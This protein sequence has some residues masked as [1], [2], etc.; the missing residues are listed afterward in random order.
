MAE[1][2]ITHSIINGKLML[3][4]KEGTILGAQKVI[5]G[6]ENPDRREI[7]TNPSSG[8]NYSRTAVEAQEIYCLQTQKHSP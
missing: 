1:N 8:L 4:G 6:V 7:L 3:D 5:V 2:I